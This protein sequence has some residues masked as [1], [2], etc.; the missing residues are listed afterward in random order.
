MLILTFKL[1]LNIAILKAAFF[2]ILLSPLNIDL[3]ILSS[4]F[5]LKLGIPLFSR[6]PDWVS[7]FTL[8]ECACSSQPVQGGQAEHEE[9]Y[10][11]DFLDNIC[12]FMDKS[13]VIF[14]GLLVRQ[15]K[16]PGKVFA[17]DIL[18]HLAEFLW[19]WRQI[20]F[21][22]QSLAALFINPCGNFGT[23]VG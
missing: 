23:L 22:M 13:V 10:S 19:N 3:S 8:Q 17:F 11:C 5:N 20:F 1:L 14:S 16:M 21:Q 6:L 4:C 7:G 9:K 2:I 18:Q 12:I 15:W